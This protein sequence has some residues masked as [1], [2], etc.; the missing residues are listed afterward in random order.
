MMKETPQLT[1]GVVG[2]R[3]EH[4]NEHCKERQKDD[5]VYRKIQKAKKIYRGRS[6]GRE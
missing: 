5:K 1:D 3:N 4:C 2:K 6:T